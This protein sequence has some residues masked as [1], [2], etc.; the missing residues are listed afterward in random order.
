MRRVL[1]G[2]T[3]FVSGFVR[4]DTFCIEDFGQVWPDLRPYCQVLVDVLV[5]FWPGFGNVKTGG[6]GSRRILAKITK[7]ISVTYLPLPVASA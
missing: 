2:L 1:S 4:F 6:G 7:K 5:Q 3:G